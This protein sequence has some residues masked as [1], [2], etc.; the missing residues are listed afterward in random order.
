[1]PYYFAVRT[2]FLLLVTTAAWAAD[3]VLHVKA[4]MRIELQS[5]VRVPGGVVVRGAL[6]DSA[7]EEP[8]AGRTV[9]IAVDGPNG[10]YRYAE[11]T[12]DDGSFRWRVPLPLGRYTVRLAAGGDDEYAA[13]PVLERS[14]DVERGTPT[15]TLIAPESVSARASEVHIAVEMRDAADQLD[16]ADIPRGRPGPPAELPVTL[17]LATGQEPRPFGS[18]VTRF[19]RLDF[20][21]PMHELGK[22]GQK[23]T[24]T[25]RFDGDAM[26]NPTQAVR[27]LLVTSPTILTVSVD[28]ERAAPDDELTFSGKLG[29]TDGPVVSGMIDLEVGR[30]SVGSAVTDGQGRYRTRLRGAALGLGPVAVQARFR[31]QGHREASAAGPVTITVRGASFHASPWYLVPPLLTALALLG[32]AVARRRPWVAVAARIRARAARQAPS[33]GLSEGRTNILRTLRPANDFGLAGQVCDSATLE[34]IV[35]ATLVVDIGGEHRSAVS[36]GD[37]RFALEA[38]PAGTLGVEVAAAGYVSER[39]HRTV[40]HRGELRGARVLLVPIRARIFAAYDRAARPLLPKADQG[41]V[42]TPRELLAHVRGQRLVTDDL[43][44]LT[45]AVEGH[46]YGP[47]TPDLEA[48]AEVESL[49]ERVKPTT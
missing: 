14:L 12:G 22:A 3:P 45:S 31:A 33:S 7:L 46:V 49:V 27:T 34:P 36:G 15:L 2:A 41:E 13:A 20:T 30:N 40:P 39:F 9:A 42:V 11:P 32:M 18:G 28:P 19:G 17:L 23:V 37:G 43:A 44:S 4:R 10:F 29:D 48:L 21:V 35:G 5:V 6:F 16:E 24:L 26:R 38:L 47:R 8:I 25:A 1:L